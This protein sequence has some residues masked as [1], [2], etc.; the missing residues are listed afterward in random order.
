MIILSFI[1]G[2]IALWCFWEATMLCFS[3]YDTRVLRATLVII[4]VICGFINVTIFTIYH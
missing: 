1:F 4:G 3:K 2:F